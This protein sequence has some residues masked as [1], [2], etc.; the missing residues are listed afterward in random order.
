MDASNNN[1]PLLG[2]LLEQ[3]QTESGTEWKL[4]LQ[5]YFRVHTMH[6]S[7][8][9]VFSPEIIV[10]SAVFSYSLWFFIKETEAK[11]YLSYVEYI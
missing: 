1:S 7:L 2:V 8:S 3:R 6:N 10:L 5:T 4:K 11:T 9:K